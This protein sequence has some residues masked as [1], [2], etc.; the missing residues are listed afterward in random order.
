MNQDETHPRQLRRYAMRIVLVGHVF[1]TLA[2][3]VSTRI[4]HGA[5][6]RWPSRV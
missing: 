6:A 4:S 2:F 3:V 1:L 5:N